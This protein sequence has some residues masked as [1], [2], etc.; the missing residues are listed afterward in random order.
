M[1]VARQSS[2]E[3][4][5]GRLRSERGCSERTIASYRFDLRELARL[6]GADAV[7]SSAA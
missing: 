1:A 7:S 6:A 5:L 4:Y 2:V 3:R